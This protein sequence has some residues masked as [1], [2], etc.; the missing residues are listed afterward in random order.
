MLVLTRKQ[1]EMIQIGDSIV[2]KVIATGRGKVKIGIE[3]PSNVRVLRG[4]LSPL[5]QQFAAPAKTRPIIGAEA[6]C[7]VAH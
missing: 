2:I 4:E 5:A 6:A 1:D 7:H 3:A